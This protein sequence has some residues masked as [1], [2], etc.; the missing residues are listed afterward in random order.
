MAVNRIRR[1][2]PMWLAALTMAWLPAAE[3]DGETVS[4]SA[5]SKVGA[6]VVPPGLYRL[7]VQ[8]ALVFFT[9]VATKKSFSALVRVEKTAKKSSFTAAQARAVE[10]GQQVDVIVLQGADYKLVF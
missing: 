6:V 8:G 5:P 10:G 9:D 2:A 3:V 4:F 1:L 7:K